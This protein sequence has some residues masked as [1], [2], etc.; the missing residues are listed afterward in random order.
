MYRK[1]STCPSVI[2]NDIFLKKYFVYN[3]IKCLKNLIYNAWSH[4]CTTCARII[5]Q[6]L[7]LLL[8]PSFYPFECRSWLSQYTD[9]TPVWNV[10]WGNTIDFQEFYLFLS[11]C[12]FWSTYFVLILRERC[13]AR[14]QISQ[15]FKHALQIFTKPVSQTINPLI[16]LFNNKVT[17]QL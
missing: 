13:I 7:K 5:S 12:V 16:L 3:K 1:K 4:I 2:L 6:F 10:I 8:L 17:Y 9:C 14:A 11:P 15:F